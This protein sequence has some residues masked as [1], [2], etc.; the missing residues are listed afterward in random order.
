MICQINDDETN[1][2]LNAGQKLSKNH[3]DLMLP[4]RV[5]AGST[6]QRSAD[7]RRHKHFSRTLHFS[8]SVRMHRTI[9]VLLPFLISIQ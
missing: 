7:V 3:G 9:K 1:S 6:F 4:D 8:N 2:A 5:I